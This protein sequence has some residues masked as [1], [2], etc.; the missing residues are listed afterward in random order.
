MASGNMGDLW[1]N[2]G[3][4]D[5][6]PQTLNRILRAVSEADGSVSKLRENFNKM[7]QRWKHEA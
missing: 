5:T 6:T 3:I 4:K 7:L 2:L 1:F